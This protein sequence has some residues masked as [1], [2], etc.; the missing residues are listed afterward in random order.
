MYFR[1]AILCAFL[2]AGCDGDDYPNETVS[3]E[4]LTTDQ[5]GMD[6]NVQTMDAETDTADN[7]T[8]VYV[9]LYTFRGN[10]VQWVNLADQESLTLLQDATTNPF[11][12]NLYP[13]TGKPYGIDYSRSVTETSGGEEMTIALNR[14]TGSAL[15]TLVRTLEPTTFTITPS[16]TPFIPTSS[17][18]LDWTGITGYEYQITL[19]FS[20]GD[21]EQYLQTV[22]LP[23]SYFPTI[24]VSPFVIRFSDYFYFP[25]DTSITTCQLRASLWSYEDQSEQGDPA[26]ENVSITA[27]RVQ[28]LSV[29]VQRM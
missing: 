13:A 6:V 27:S 22:R 15:N 3:S 8:H 24:P 18:T 20:C 9:T 2:L 25:S 10:Y 4:N 23:N 19:R 21:T 12:K 17:L 1:S 29:P 14:P 16:S 7:G 28:R 11:T 26:F 5:I